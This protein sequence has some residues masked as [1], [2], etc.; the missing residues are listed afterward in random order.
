MLAEGKS[1]VSTGSLGR[2][3]LLNAESLYQL[4]EFVGDELAVWAGRTDRTTRHAETALTSQFC[5]H[6]NSAAH[7][8]GWDF[9]QFRTEVPDEEKASR[10]IDLS[11]SPCNAVIE[12]TGRIVSDLDMLLP[13]E[14]KRLPTP[15]DKDREETEYVYTEKSTTGGIQRFKEGHHGSRHSLAAMIG[16]VQEPAILSWLSK[17]ISWVDNRVSANIPGWSNSDR[18][19]AVGVSN[20]PVSRYKSHHDRQGGLEPIE[21]RHYWLDLT[22]TKAKDATR[23]EMADPTNT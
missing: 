4:L 12:V 20:G 5:N 17:V 14:C 10:A 9:I 13:I 23:P 16:F 21:I 22:Q 19:T 11:I 3:V 15:K 6:L 7:R 2:N 8:S 1:S 18:P